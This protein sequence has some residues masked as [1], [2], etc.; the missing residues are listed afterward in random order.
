MAIHQDT[1]A[2]DRSTGLKGNV[3]RALSAAGIAI[4]QLA[5]GP[6]TAFL[7]VLVLL[8]TAVTAVTSPVGVGCS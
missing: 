5:S 4:T 2:G 1:A 8:W 7:A 6:N 3:V